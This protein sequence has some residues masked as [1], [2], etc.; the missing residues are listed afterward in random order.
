MDLPDAIDFVRPSI[1]QVGALTAGE[2]RPTVLGTGFLIHAHGYAVTARH[3]TRAA[4]R[5][6]ASTQIVVSLAM[7]N[8][9]VGGVQL[10][11]N[12][13]VERCELVEEDPRHDLALV[14]LHRNPV[15]AG[16]STGMHVGEG[17]VAIGAM[18]GVAEADMTRPR[19]GEP[20]AVSGYPLA[21]PVLI[22]TSGAIA[23]AWAT[24][25]AD[26]HPPGTPEGF[27]MPDIRDSY[28]ADVAVNPG[29]SGGPAY[30]VRDGRVLGVCV[31]F[32]TAEAR[33]GEAED[34]FRYNS[35]LCIIV[36]I[37]YGLALLHRHA[38]A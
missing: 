30:T 10:R 33:I 2:H 37:Q 38:P 14:K 26:V 13:K 21:N 25:I 27:V 9:D 23:S 11:G 7:P 15:A 5:L 6:G 20:V 24:D 8:M 36:P 22:T 28:I 3:V 4:Q 32:Q 35:G 17:S 12:F 16:G 34:L 19:D 31:A 18:S 1:V 29:N